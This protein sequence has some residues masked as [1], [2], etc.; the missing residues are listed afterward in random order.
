MVDDVLVSIATLDV[1]A[2]KD[3][4]AALGSL[5]GEQGLASVSLHR[6]VD[7]LWYQLPTKWM[8]ELAEKLRI[9]AALGR[10]FELVGM[11][12]YA[13]VCTSATTTEILHAYEQQSHSAGLSAYRRALAAS[14]VQSPDVPG[15]LVWGASLGN[16]EAA[17]YWAVANRLE[18]ACAAGEFTP[19]TRGWRGTVRQLTAEFLT[20]HPVDLAGG[21]WL[22][23]IH[24]ERLGHWADSHGPLRAALTRRIT[25]QL[26]TS[27]DMPDDAAST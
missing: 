15:L 10:L 20:A 23:R 26:I 2:A 19:G 7:F 24:T 9:A 3:A 12:R 8:C 5:T 11:P 25:N 27:V 14:G 21:A 1:E 22:D 13:A 16:D 6:V 18:L 4:R 17:A